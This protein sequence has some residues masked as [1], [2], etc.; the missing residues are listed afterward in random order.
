MPTQAKFT[1]KQVARA[2]GVSE[3]SIKRWVDSGKIEAVRTA[4]GHRKV[5]LSSIVQLARDQGYTIVR[6]EVLGLAAESSKCNLQDAR[7][8]LL[9][10]L[11]DGDESA[12]Q[13][14]IEPLYHNGLTM[15]EI[16]DHVLAPVF[17]EI[18]SRSAHRRT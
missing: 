16:A 3:S 10:T 8:Q 7:D 2:L 12:S 4:G 14:I 15:V 13:A 18:G 1:P 9:E 17:H 5:L 11:I 6:P